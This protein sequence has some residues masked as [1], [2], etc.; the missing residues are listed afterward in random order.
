MERISVSSEKDVVDAVC[1]TRE[2][3]RTLEI[4][5]AGT[6]RGYGRPVVCDDVLELSGL[7]GMVKYEPG[8]LVITALAGTP[9]TEIEAALAEK[10]QRLGFE[11]ADW[12]PLFGAPA[13]CA[14]I[15]GALAADT[16][17]SA[18]VKFG[19]ARDHLLGF[20]AVNGLGEAYKAGGRVVKNVTGF[21][22]PKLMC[23]AMGTLGPMTEVTLRVFPRA[24]HATIVA[25]DD[26]SA[27]AGLALLR[28]VWSSPLE[29]TGLAF[30]NNSAFVRLEGSR[31]ALD[32]K[33]AMLRGLSD[34]GP[35]LVSEDDEPF[36][37]IASGRIADVSQRALWRVHLPPAN[38][39][40]LLSEVEAK[41]WCADRAGG[42]LW[43]ACDDSYD[44]HS[45][46]RRFDAHSTLIRGCPGTNSPFGPEDRARTELTNS[47]KGAFDPLRIF[48]PGRMWE[49]V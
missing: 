19:R 31:L 33:V 38:A 35:R 6:K 34:H 27:K 8:E 7:C 25:F 36:R 28:R 10:N 46:A 44:M 21:D 29:A 40:G 11:P 30:H 41:T 47:V 5:G 32:E 16:S 9:V 18:A 49:G 15:G 43:I 39:I 13:N 48:N 3:K 22:L 14:T 17:G 42:L 20:R 2:S 24:S 45:L 12:G 1:A 23:G 37:V 4:V 26:L